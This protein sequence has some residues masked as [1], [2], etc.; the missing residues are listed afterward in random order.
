MAEAAEE[1][2]EER[3][4]RQRV[5]REKRKPSPGLARRATGVAT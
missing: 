5:E 3:E 1:T 4:P 2:A